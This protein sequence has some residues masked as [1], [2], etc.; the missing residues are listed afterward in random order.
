LPR[1]GESAQAA[2]DACRKMKCTA[3]KMFIRILIYP[4][5][6]RPATSVC[7]VFTCLYCALSALWAKDRSK[8]L[9]MPYAKIW[10]LTLPPVFSTYLSKTDK[11]ASIQRCA[12]PTRSATGG[13]DRR[14]AFRLNFEKAG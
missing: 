7:L 5:Q 3:N 4:F 2:I 13:R 14:L 8:D 10:M 11:G 1:G 6:L 9:Q 12:G